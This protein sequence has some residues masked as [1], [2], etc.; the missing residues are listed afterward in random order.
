LDLQTVKTAA[1]M[2]V[3]ALVDCGATRDFIDSEYVISRN[4]LVQPLSQP[5]PVLNVDGSPNQAGGIT[6][7]VDMVVDYEGHSERIQLAVTRI[8]KQHVILGYS[9][10][11][12]HNL[13]IDWETQEVQMMRC[14]TGCR[15]CRDELQAVRMNEKLAASILRQLREGPTLYICAVN[16]EEWHGDSGYDPADNNDLPELCPDSEDDDDEED[17]LEEGDRIP[18]TVFAPVEEIR[19]GSTVSQHLAEAYTRNSAPAGTDVP[20]WAA[21]FSDVFS[22]ESF[23]SLLE[24]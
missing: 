15:T 4:L 18:Y 22:K 9:G 19:T 13:K 17:D 8:R 3:K 6:G 24:K 11:Q 16:S 12:K 14:P 1:R 7:V 23:D 10:L 20:P 2:S 5:I 21:D